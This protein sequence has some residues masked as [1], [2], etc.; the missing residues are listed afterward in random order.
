MD[1]PTFYQIRV[2]GHL[3]DT[4]GDWFEGLKISNHENGEAMLSGLITDQSALYGVLNRFSSL[5]FT[6]ISV[7][8][9]PEED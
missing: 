3:D 9:V 8:A 7:N 5:G 1:I 6:L 4:W 2:A